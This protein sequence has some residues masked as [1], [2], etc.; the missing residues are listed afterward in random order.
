AEP[1]G[2]RIISLKDGSELAQKAPPSLEAPSGPLSGHDVAPQPPL[3]PSPKRDSIT[4]VSEISQGKFALGT[5]SGNIIFGEVKF[6]GTFVEGGRK[7]ETDAV[8]SD[9]VE[10]SKG[11]PLTP[12]AYAELKDGKLAVAAVGPREIVVTRITEQ[13][14]LV[15]P[16]ALSEQTS[17]LPLEISGEIS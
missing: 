17:R 12:L 2:L 15:G 7:T 3:S 1:G 13:K 9:P 16:S 8:F 11:Q 5:R 4:A 10:V 14:A 6:D